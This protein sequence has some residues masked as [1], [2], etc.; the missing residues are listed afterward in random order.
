M[1]ESY[2]KK[3]FNYETAQYGN[4]G[5][6]SSGKGLAPVLTPPIRRQHRDG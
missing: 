1:K 6:K 4:N 3:F 5:M 2:N